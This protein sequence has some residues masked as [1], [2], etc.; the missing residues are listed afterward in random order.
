MVENGCMKGIDEVYGC[1]QWP[2]ASLG[3]LWCK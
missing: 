1:H 3:E 2:T